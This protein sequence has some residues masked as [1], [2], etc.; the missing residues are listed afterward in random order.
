PCQGWGRGFESHR[1][2]QFAMKIEMVSCRGSNA[3]Q[4][5]VCRGSMGEAHGQGSAFPGDPCP[6]AAELRR[7]TTQ[8]AQPFANWRARRDLSLDWLRRCLSGKA[9]ACASS[10]MGSGSRKL[11]AASVPRPQNFCVSTCKHWRTARPGAWH[12]FGV[13]RAVLQCLHV[14]TQKF[15]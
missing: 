9:R 1:P 2:L 15:W 3:L 6:G 13:V 14:D 11:C 4:A 7:E 12:Q 5:P 10:V 8:T